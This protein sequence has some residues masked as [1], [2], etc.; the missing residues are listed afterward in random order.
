V[1]L[2]QV[3]RLA[4][5][6]HLGDEAGDL[7]ERGIVR[8]VRTPRAEL[9]VADDA[10]TIVRQLQER[11]QVF[12][13]AAGTAVE[14]EQRALARTRALVP[15]AAGANADVS[16]LSRDYEEAMILRRA[17]SPAKTTEPAAEW[18]VLRLGR[19][20]VAAE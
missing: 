3:E 5:S 11:R 15:D 12:G 8:L 7:P 19:D 16:L 10:K 4:D 13:I 14:E 9:V 20:E 18:N 1:H 2:F 6:L 17:T